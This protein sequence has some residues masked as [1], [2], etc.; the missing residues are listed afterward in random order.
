[1]R[2]EETSTQ[3]PH[4]QLTATTTTSVPPP[5]MEKHMKNS[6]EDHHYHSESAAAAAAAVV[7]STRN[8]EPDDENDEPEDDNN[9]DDDDDGIIIDLPG[10]DEND[11]NYSGVVYDDEP[12]AE[13]EM[14]VFLQR[15][16][17][18]NHNHNNNNNND[19]Y[20]TTPS[21]QQP[22]SPATTPKYIIAEDMASSM[23]FYTLCTALEAVWNASVR[24]TT[25]TTHATTT[26]STS[27]HSQRN[28]TTKKWSDTQ[29]LWKLL[30]PKFLQHLQDASNT[31]NTTNTTDNN[32]NTTGTRTVQSIF[33]ILRL[34]LPEKDGSRQFQMAE[35]TISIMYGNALGLSSTQSSK[36][37]MLLNYTDPNYVTSHH[38]GL[39]DLSL[40]VQTVVAT[41][42]IHQPS[43]YTIGHINAAL[44]V[45]S[46]LPAK[47]KQMKSN[48]DW[49]QNTTTKESTEARS[50]HNKKKTP[51]KNTSIKELRIQ[52]LRQ[53]NDGTF[54]SSHSNTNTNTNNSSDGTNHG[55][56]PL[57]HKWL[58]R[59]LLRKMQFG[60]VRFS[61]LLHVNKCMYMHMHMISCTN[62][63][64]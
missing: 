47:A 32:M 21:P 34:L 31:S 36:Y 41:T 54:R 15:S 12:L 38:D 62:V 33:P 25:T 64:T 53:L 6:D 44:D 14:D 46:T 63:L 39:G 9:N 51:K 26:T 24:T 40:V 43:T 48:H 18:S 8:T 16:M 55:L 20:S 52:W 5:V 35:S 42:K 37:K 28:S 50:P 13:G 19:D 23:K 45:L 57:E 17:N 29:K 56:S 2:H 22:N 7:A 61:V 1:M 27:F 49:K 58:V 4:T 30:P 60:L 11:N 3:I 59:I 10:D